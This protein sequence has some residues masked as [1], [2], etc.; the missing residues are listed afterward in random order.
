MQ[1]FFYLS[2]NRE[3]LGPYSL[4]RVQQMLERGQVLAT[5]YIFLEEI[6]DW[7][8]LLEFLPQKAQAK[9]S[10]SKVEDVKIHE[11]DWFVLQDQ[12]RFGPYSHLEMIKMLQDKAIHEYDYVWCPAM[13]D[14]KKLAEVE[15]FSQTALKV[16]AIKE[17]IPRARRRY[18][19]ISLGASLVIHNG[20]KVWKAESIEI[21]EGGC[22]ITMT[23]SMLEP[24]SKVTIL[25]KPNH[26]LPP[27]HAVCEI[28]SKILKGTSTIYGVK[29]LQVEKQI[30]KSIKAAAKKAA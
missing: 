27:F 10:K 2:K 26:L 8:S 3:T 20:Q 17:T 19:R 6:Q 24:G 21:G 23:D 22:Q 5:D 9:P 4:E 12:K 25:F 18:P 30:K 16:I 28:V 15:D 1:K 7:I 29:F 11:T 13:T 14:W